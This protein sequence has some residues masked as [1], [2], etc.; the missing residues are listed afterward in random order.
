MQIN[1]IERPGV[2]RTAQDIAARVNEITFNA[3]LQGELRAIDFV[4]RLL[5]AGRLDDSHYKR[6]L[7]HVVSDD[8]A[9]L[10]L[11]VNAKM[12]TDMAF[13]ETLFGF[14]RASCDTWIGAHFDDLGAR[15]TVDLRQMF[16]GDVGPLGAARHPPRI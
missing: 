16:Q 5:D 7:I 15:G 6:M 9:L 12:N 13:F 11:G 2:P 1:P 10:P 14:G 4:A 3:S 8:A